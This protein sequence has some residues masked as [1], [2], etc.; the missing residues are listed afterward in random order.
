VIL[1]LYIVRLLLFLPNIPQLIL[2]EVD[3]VFPTIFAVGSNVADE[4]NQCVDSMDVSYPRF[5]VFPHHFHVLVP[6]I[7]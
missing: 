6:L 7:M 5:F 1:R 3:S 4:P 2:M